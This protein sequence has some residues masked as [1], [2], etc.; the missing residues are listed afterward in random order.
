MASIFNRVVNQLKL[1]FCFIIQTF[2]ISWNND[3]VK[4]L[5]KSL[6][7]WWTLSEGQSRVE[8]EFVEGVEVVV[9]EIQRGK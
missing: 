1:F 5:V 6:Q 9:G 2:V 7:R 3:F 8:E 4:G